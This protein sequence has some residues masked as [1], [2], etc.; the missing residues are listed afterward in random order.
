MGRQRGGVATGAYGQV[1]TVPNLI[2]F[3]RLLGVPLFLYLFLVPQ[4]DVAAVVVLAIGGTSDWIDGYL[5]RRLGQ[6]S[7]LGELLD[8]FADR[9]YILATLLAFSIRGIVPWWF[10]VALLARD[11]VMLI[12]LALLQRAGQ[13]PPPVHYVG[14][15]ATFILLMAFPMLLLADVTDATGWY[16]SGWALAWWGLVLYWIAAI[17]YLVQARTLIRAHRGVVLG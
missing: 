9:L 8:P 11:A 12:C 5:A 10:T 4:A 7:K 17:F 6:V 15:T 3:A 1:W 16:A 14:K 2:S 13:G